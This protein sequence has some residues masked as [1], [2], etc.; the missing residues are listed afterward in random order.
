MDYLTVD[1][2]C[3]LNIIVNYEVSN[4]ASV[5]LSTGIRD[6]HKRAQPSTR[7]APREG[8]GDIRAQSGE[9]Q[10]QGE[11]GTNIL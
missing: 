3:C 10:Y 7:T 2:D 8:R 11:F 9:K 6:S 1:C 4:V 5:C